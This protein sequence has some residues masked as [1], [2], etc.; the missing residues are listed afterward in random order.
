MTRL[1]RT[2]RGLALEPLA[3]LAEIHKLGVTIHTREDGDNTIARASDAIKPI[4]RV[5][6]GALENEARTDKATEKWRNW[7]A[8]GRK[9]TYRPYGITVDDKG[10]DLPDEPRADAIRTAFSMRAAGTG[11]L[12][13]TLW[14]AA[15]AP[16]QPMRDGS[17]RTLKWGRGHIQQILRNEAYRGT[18]VPEAV[19]DDA[20]RVENWTR[21]RK[22]QRFDWPLSGALRCYCGYLLTGTASGGGCAKCKAGLRIHN[23]QRVRYYACWNPLKPHIE[24]NPHRRTRGPASKPGP[25]MRYL[26]AD[27][28]EVAF[29]TLLKHLTES[30]QLVARYAS[31]KRLSTRSRTALDIR[32]RT[33]ESDLK[34]IDA[35]RR[36]VWAL[37][38][39]GKVQED[40]IQR[41]LDAIKNEDREKRSVLDGLLRQRSEQERIDTTATDA[42]DMIARSSALWS[43]AMTEDRKA[44]SQAVARY[45]GG[46]TVDAAGDLQCGQLWSMKVPPRP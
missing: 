4:L 18:V 25:K 15:N 21:P 28:L 2:G 40:D 22:T 27:D 24:V 1:D 36:K 23:H 45:L 35:R 39:S 11:Q 34:Q 44:M 9:G 16:P 37:F 26:R 41:E 19:W 8:A 7:K 38:E 20:Q 13:I 31:E 32:I 14:L 17:E 6:T 12:A 30:P 10:H 3:A 42:S 29:G 5:L 33:I 46:I 43:L